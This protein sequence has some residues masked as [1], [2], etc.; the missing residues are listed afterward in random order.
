MLHWHRREVTGERMIDV[1]LPVMCQHEAGLL[2]TKHL[3]SR[4]STSDTAPTT[5]MHGD[6]GGSEVALRERGNGQFEVTAYAQ[7]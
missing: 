7:A 5:P 6:C 4:C 1:V 2:K 3:P